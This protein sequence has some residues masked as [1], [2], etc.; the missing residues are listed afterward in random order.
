MNS[1]RNPGLIGRVSQIKDRDLIVF[2]DRRSALRGELSAD[3]VEDLVGDPAQPSDALRFENIARPD[4][5][6][7]GSA[8]AFA[9]L[10]VQDDP[11]EP[12]RAQSLAVDG[13]APN[14]ESP[15]SRP[16]PL[17]LEL[18]LRPRVKSS[19]CS[20]RRSGVGAPSAP[21]DC[22]PYGCVGE[23]ECRARRRLPRLRPAF[24]K[25]AKLRRFESDRAPKGIRKSAGCKATGIFRPRESPMPPRTP[26]IRPSPR[27]SGSESGSPRATSQTPAVTA[28]P[29]REAKCSHTA[30]RSTTGGRPARGSILPARRNPKEMSPTA[31]AAARGLPEQPERTRGS[32]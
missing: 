7:Q 19:R 29:R 32:S 28:T 14:G 2:E 15:P 13:G 8:A 5:L 18:P 16:T 31:A 11:V 24:R 3:L 21:V 20:R 9:T 23:T 17:P 4:L 10:L 26:P 6:R 22:A 25:A 27:S 30:R 1:S 12:E